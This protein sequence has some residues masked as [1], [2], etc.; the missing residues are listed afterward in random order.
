M[1]LI[2]R[3][4]EDLKSAMKAHQVQTVSTLRMLQSAIKNAVIAARTTAKQELDDADIEQVV[5]SEVKK[6]KDALEDFRTAARQDLIDK[7]NEE[8]EVLA[9][10]LP[11][12]LDSEVLEKIVADTIA[13]LKTAGE[14]DFGKAMK[15]ITAKVKGAADGKQISELVKKALS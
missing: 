2:Q 4:E 10:Y 11:K 6:L 8:L 7:T 3:I 9:G 5:K 15:A 13:E 12:Q 1:K 14:I